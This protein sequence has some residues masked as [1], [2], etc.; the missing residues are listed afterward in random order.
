MYDIFHWYFTFLPLEEQE[1][2]HFSIFCMESEISTRKKIRKKSVF[3]VGEIW[4][5]NFNFFS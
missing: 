3:P 1:H 5:A 4:G 2:R